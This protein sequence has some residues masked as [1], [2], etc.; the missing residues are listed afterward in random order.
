VALLAILT[1]QQAMSTRRREEEEAAA[2]AGVGVGGGSPHPIERRF[3]EADQ[4]FAAACARAPR[5]CW[6]CLLPSQIGS[7]GSPLPA[8]AAV[9]D[10]L[11]RVIED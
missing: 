1:G 2:A 9:A 7:G 10:V 11:V 3:A 6:R 4:A 5:A 8:A